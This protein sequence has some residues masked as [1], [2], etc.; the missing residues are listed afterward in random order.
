MEAFFIIVIAHFFK[1]EGAFGSEID[2]D[3]I[4]ANTSKIRLIK[5]VVEVVGLAETIASVAWQPA[6]LAAA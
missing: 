4:P 6:N 2:L 3:I 5:A 1:S